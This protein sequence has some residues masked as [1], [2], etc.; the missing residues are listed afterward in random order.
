MVNNQG[1]PQ[2]MMI[3]SASVSVMVNSSSFQVS[4]PECEIK[5]KQIAWIY[6]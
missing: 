5:E 1:A 4:I 3:K 2:C 6:C